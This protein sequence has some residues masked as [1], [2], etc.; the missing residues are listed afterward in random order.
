[1]TCIAWDGKTLAADKMFVRGDTIGS[2][3]KI[4]AYRDVTFASYGD[5][6]LGIQMRD[7]LLSD[8]KPWPKPDAECF[9][10]LVVLDGNGIHFYESGSS[11]VPIYP[12]D[13]ICAWGVGRE[14]ALGAMEMGADAV[15]AVEV[16][17]KWVGGCGRGV[18]SITVR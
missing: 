6:S 17:S 7:H 4:W 5:L 16:A 8:E 11:P 1:M 10:G 15:R 14:A 9:A 18:D 12:T 3:L 13:N 2:V